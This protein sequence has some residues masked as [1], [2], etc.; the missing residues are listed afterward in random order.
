M[1]EPNDNQGKYHLINANEELVKENVRKFM[2]KTPDMCQ[3]EKCFLDVCA[4]VFN[5]GYARFAT[6]TEGGLMARV[7]DMNLANHAGLVVAITEGIELVKRSP[8]H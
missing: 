6:T 5:K 1:A 3:C 7:P 8:Q 2:A 4:I